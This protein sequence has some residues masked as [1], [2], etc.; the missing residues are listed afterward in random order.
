MR[1]PFMK[2]A[3]L[4]C[5]LSIVSLVH[6]VEDENSL[7][8]PGF[9]KSRNGVLLDWRNNTSSPLETIEVIAENPKFVRSGKYAAKLMQEKKLDSGELRRGHL[10]S[11]QDVAIAPNTKYSL[12]V[13]V[14]GA[15]K[16]AVL[17]YLYSG[18]EGKESF[19]STRYL[20]AATGSNTDAAGD[21]W[22][23]QQYILDTARLDAKVTKARFVLEAS[24]VAYV[25]DATFTRVAAMPEEK[26]DKTAPATKTPDAPEPEVRPNLMGIGLTDAPPK[27]DGIIEKGEYSAASTGLIDNETQAFYPLRNKFAMSYDKQKFYFALSLQLPS[28]YELNPAGKTRDDPALVA[29]E[30]A[31]YFFLRPDDD[32]AA[33]GYKGLYLG[34]SPNG[35]IYDAWEAVHWVEMY[36]N[37]DTELQADWDM[38]TVEKNGV[39]TIEFAVP[40]QGTRLPVPK[41]GTTYMSSFGFNLQHTRIAW[42]THSSWFDHY[43]AFGQLRFEEAGTKFEIPTLGEISR[44]ELA[45]TFDLQ[46]QTDAGL[47]FDTTYLVSTPRMI[48]GQIGGYVYDVALDVTQ[49]QA[50]SDQA[51]YHW[52]KDGKLAAGQAANSQERAAL[53]KPGFYVLEVET[54]LGDKPLSY[55]R[56]PFKYEPPLVANFTPIPSRDTIEMLLQLH[57]ARDEERGAVQIEFQDGAGKT[58]LSKTVAVT[59]DEIVVPVSMKDLQPDNY[60]VLF[61][62][63]GKDK[64]P[65]TT[66]EDSFRKWPDPEWLRER[67]GIVALD[68]DWLPAPWTP[69]QAQ[70]NKVSL[71]GREYS[72]GAGS[73]LQKITSQNQAVLGGGMTVKYLQGGKEHTVAIAAPTLKQEGK[74]RATVSQQGTSPHFALQSKQ[75]VEFDGMDRFDMSITPEKPTPV[76]KMWIEIPIEN[77]KYWFASNRE[78]AAGSRWQAG[79]IP[80]EGV[81][82]PARYEWVWMGNDDVG[83]TFFAE[84]YK[85]WLIDSQKPRVELSTSGG[86]N[87]IRLLI[88]NEPSQ[89]GAP[90]NI[91]FGLFPTPVKPP[92]DNWRETRAQGL[93]MK[94]QPVSLNIVSPQYWNSA[95]SKPSPR[96]WQALRDMVQL[97]HQRGQKIHPYMGMLYLSPYDYIKRDFPFTLF[98]GGQGFPEEVLLRK[99]DEATKVEDYFYFKEDWTLR[100]HN[101]MTPEWETREEVRTTPSGSWA[102]Y[103]VHGIDEMLEKSDVDGFFLDIDNPMMNFDKSKG[104]AYRTKDGVEE[105]TTE[106][107]ALR[108]MYKRLYY[109]FD[110]RRGP[111]RKPYMLGHGFAVAAPYMSFWDA[112]VNGEAIKPGEKFETTK[113]VTQNILIGDPLTKAAPEEDARSYDAFALRAMYGAHSGIPNLFL[114]QYSYKP[115]FKINEHSREILS[116]TFPTDVRL[117]SAYI[118]PQPVYDFWSKVEVPFGMGDTTFFPYWTNNV[119]SSPAS[120]RVS[121]WKKNDAED[122]L[123]AVA[124]WAGAEINA[125]VLLPPHLARLANRLEMESGAKVDAGDSLSAT[126]PAHDL[127]VFRLKEK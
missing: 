115:E 51:V 50:I 83:L 72:Y 45:P 77:A 86:K 95:Y 107:F 33:K 12:G 100:P 71:W 110:T 62:L 25:D 57:G 126:I 16:V 38:K 21:D 13:W 93:V 127:R 85:G 114:S 105:G 59:D 15:G 11:N 1:M 49:Q 18:P 41:P 34:V 102:D 94:E 66:V 10:H 70:G 89:V 47:P 39:L 74:G 17:T 80:E 44:G 29:A 87:V 103:F 123:V 5:C 46:N 122:Y 111:K 6:A 90:L 75:L 40:W 99:K 60:K 28:G 3:L 79:L 26:T 22:R 119:Q 97:A 4:L 64:K 116:L 19:H 30:D 36:A 91:T 117:W 67:K 78:G 113:L 84:N 108:D 121:Y 32:V 48:A 24:G 104:L 27:I 2:A 82:R 69:V 118:P 14:K 55:Q 61:K 73:L 9:E 35:T 125:R 81:S 109:V 96:S 88:V 112:T 56:L 106:Q 37:R 31:F 20:P 65:V 58:A 53:K 76:E 52:K 120:A 92:F 42:Q 23:H 8:D 54:R 124:N 98:E 101:S 68:A 43:Q 7:S 63:T